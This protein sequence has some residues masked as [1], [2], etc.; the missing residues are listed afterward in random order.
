MPVLSASKKVNKLEVAVAN[1]VF[2]KSH[3]GR[4]LL[5]KILQLTTQVVSRHKSKSPHKLPRV[6]P[7]GDA[8]RLH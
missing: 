4:C 3:R 5:T 2:Y 1:L 6:T 7:V 8:H